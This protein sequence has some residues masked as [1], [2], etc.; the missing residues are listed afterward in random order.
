MTKIPL[1][2]RALL[3]PVL[4]PPWAFQRRRS[5]RSRRRNPYTAY[6]R[7]LI[8]IPASLVIATIVLRA[9]ARWLMHV[10]PVMFGALVFQSLVLSS[11]LGRSEVVTR[12]A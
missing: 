2:C 5:P 1:F 12:I 6:A 8:I 10:A 11:F 7:P 3:L 4:G 9:S